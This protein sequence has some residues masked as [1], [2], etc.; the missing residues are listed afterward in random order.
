MVGLASLV[1]AAKVSL[2]RNGDASLIRALERHLIIRGCELAHSARPAMLYLRAFGGLSLENGGRPLVGAATQ[3]GRLAMLAVLASAG[4][5]GISRDLIL[6]L[7]WPEKD[8]ESA[9]GALRQGL[10]KLRH[11]VG[12]PELTIGTTE[13]KLNIEVIGSD[14]L[15]FD[16]EFRVGNFE[17]AVGRYTGPLLHG[18]HLSDAPEFERWA[19]R[20]RERRADQYRTALE[21]LAAAAQGRGEYRAA[22]DLWKALAASDPLS[23]TFAIATIK[24]LVRAGERPA[25]LQ[26]LREHERRVRAE[27]DLPPDP[28]LSALAQELRANEGGLPTSRADRAEPIIVASTSALK[29][30]ITPTADPA[31]HA[32]GVKPVLDLVPRAT[33]RRMWTG[34]LIAGGLVMSALALLVNNR[35]AAAVELRDNVVV[36]APVNVLAADLELWREGMVDLLSRSLD[37]AGDLRTVAPAVVMKAA[38]GAYAATPEELAYRTHAR[39]LL[40]GTLQHT[41]V[42][43]ARFTVTVRDVARQVTRGAIDRRDALDRMDHL[44]DSVAIDVLRLLLRGTSPRSPALRSVGTGS[45]VALK[46]F[47]QGQLFYRRRLWDSSETHFLRAIAL[48]SSF[49]LSYAGVARAV[50]QRP[51]A[52]AVPEAS[53]YIFRAAAF[54]HGLG[55]RDS[56]LIALDSLYMAAYANPQSL[57][58]DPQHWPHIRRAMAT[59][60]QLVNDYP[61]DAE[62][63]VRYAEV[64]YHLGGVATRTGEHDVLEAFDRALALDSALGPAYSHTGSLALLLRGREGQKRYGVSAARNGIGTAARDQQVVSELERFASSNPGR[65]R[66]VLDTLPIEVL[67]ANYQSVAATD[68]DATLFPAATTRLRI[69]IN[70]GTLGGVRESE[71]NDLTVR[72]LLKS[73]RFREAASVV[74]ARS[75]PQQFASAALLGA[76]PDHRAQPVFAAWLNQADPPFECLRLLDWWAQ[77][78]D[79]ASINRCTAKRVR[80]L[81]G[82]SASAIRRMARPIANL[83]EAFGALARHDTLRAVRVFDTFPDSLCPVWCWFALEPRARLLA[84]VGRPREALELA[85]LRSHVDFAFSAMTAPW[86]LSRARL[87]T[88]MGDDR[89]IA[90]YRVVAETWAHAD[91]SLQ[92]M[93]SEAAAAIRRLGGTLHSDGHASGR[94]VLP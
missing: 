9:R 50:E 80:E 57:P 25:A 37:G 13:L 21:K 75:Q 11:D 51:V 20:E 84:A 72:T 58:R 3:R 2:H 82:D 22:A 7:F 23:A 92:P 35:D 4:D 48:D 77:R 67:W 86:A 49:A 27:F 88:Q 18:I 64:L 30:T 33:R 39:L 59:A 85:F 70:N 65:A 71:L 44:A 55:A 38:S 79:V 53:F 42:D 43:S 17:R 10:Y 19:E 56:A 87:A 93:V 89:A 47:L 73:G 91:S 61:D 83:G 66:Q 60:E 94:K 76:L 36:V 54:N 12:E 31:R 15:E 34:A 81:Q 16:A 6:A 78:G 1:A 90:A 46:E 69:A 68:V 40:I 28:V 14:L 29:E 52:R 41:G 62:I 45:L 24:A 63:W 32:P 26:Y 5:R 74:D 8:T